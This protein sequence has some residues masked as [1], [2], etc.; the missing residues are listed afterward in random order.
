MTTSTLV[1][2]LSSIAAMPALA[3]F[4]V[5]FRPLTSSDC[6]ELA[7]LYLDSYPPGAAVATLDEALAD[8]DATFAGEYGELWHAASLVALSNDELVGS[9]QVVHQSPWDPD[10]SCPF[11]IELF[12][13][14]NRRR[15]RIGAALLQRSASIC[16]EDGQSSMALRT[17]G[18]A[19]SPHALRLYRT[20]GMRPR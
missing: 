10:L 15:Q 8:V 5:Q 17:A 2:Q 20:A 16:L 7:Q 18:N 13:E 11:V 6:E 19:A 9:I 4:D 3:P 12:V 1:G 14:P